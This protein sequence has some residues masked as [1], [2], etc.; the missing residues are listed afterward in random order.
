MSEE[1]KRILES[2]LWDIANILRG[3]MN[4][5]QFQDYIL[6]FIFYKY[7]SE[8]ILTEVNEVLAP[9]GITYFDIEEGT[10]QGDAEVTRY[11][12]EKDGETTNVYSDVNGRIVL[13][14]P[15]TYK[16][17]AYTVGKDGN[18]SGI[19]YIIF[20][21]EEEII[22]RSYEINYFYNN[23][24]VDGQ[25]VTESCPVGTTITEVPDKSTYNS[26]KY[27]LDTTKGNGTGIETLPLKVDTDT[28]K[29]I[30]N[31]YYKLDSG[32]LVIHHYDADSKN[33]EVKIVIKKQKTKY[34]KKLPKKQEKY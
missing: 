17:S 4:A 26:V 9:D 29:N 2:K 7:L 12:I 20:T 10:E 21:L 6:G 19:P 25:T 1:Q 27:E 5:N 22:I 15:G 16:I 8:K 18:R 30:I 11:K 3:K 24:K 23:I 31:V 34:L 28:S 13:I 14:Q 32:M 33:N